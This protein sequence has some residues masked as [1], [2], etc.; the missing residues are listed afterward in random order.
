LTDCHESNGL[1]GLWS[2]K[3]A[4]DIFAQ[5]RNRMGGLA[6]GLLRSFTSHFATGA[7]EAD[8]FV[9]NLIFVSE[10]LF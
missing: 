10:F 2:A 3:L 4:R 9:I 8:Y 1:L 6:K 7:L 5:Y